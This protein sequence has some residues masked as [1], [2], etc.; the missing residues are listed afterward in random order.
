M[1]FLLK[2]LVTLF[3]LVMV[4][5]FIR[6]RL[7]KGKSVSL[8]RKMVFQMIDIG[9][10]DGWRCNVFESLLGKKRI[11][12]V[13]EHEQVT[14]FYVNQAD[15]A[16]CWKTSPFKLQK[17]SQ[18]LLLTLDVQPLLLGGYGPAKITNIEFINEMPMIRK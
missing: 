18:T 12:V 15:F 16:Q 14:W 11:S 5:N 13:D 7:P 3:L 6:Y 8:E 9:Q 10:A 2:L 4:F 17:Q 1:R